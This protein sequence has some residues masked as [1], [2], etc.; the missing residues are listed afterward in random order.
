MLSN[1]QIEKRR[2]G[3]GGSDART[4]MY[5]DYSDWLA[6]YKEKVEGLRPEFTE[7]VQ[8]LME[9]GHAIEPI[10]LDRFATKVKPLK[11]LPMD[12]MVHW[13]VDPFFFFTPDGITLDDHSVQ[14]KFHTGD[15]SILDL[16]DYYAP[17]LLHEM[18]CMGRDKAHLAVIF[19]HY[20]KFMH[21]EVERDEA[22]LDA[23]LLRAMQFKDYLETGKMPEAMAAAAP[24]IQVPR[25]RDHLWPVGDNTV[26][27][28]ARQ[29][30]ET[31]AA[32]IRF[33]QALDALKKLVPND[34]ATATWVGA[35]GNGVRFK[36][37]RNGS[38]RWEPVLPA[39]N[40]EAAE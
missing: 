40:L 14:A 9:M 11:S 22:A 29:L 35:D 34:A 17:Q 6:L 12:H 1:E 25:K 3:I 24:G 30:L 15:K 5:G 18:L 28:L 16:A 21:I 7:Q 36:V 31:T 10:A 4:I 39:N 32:A 37:A 8:L 33:D 2:K 38:K 13:K 19:G 26:A 23:Y 27:P 20:G